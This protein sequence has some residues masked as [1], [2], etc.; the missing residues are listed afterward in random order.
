M[1]TNTRYLVL[2]CTV[3]MSLILYVDRVCL[4]G[5]RSEFSKELQ[6]SPEQADLVFSAFF[7]SYALSQVFAGAL[8]RAIGQRLM[9]TLSLLVWSLFTLASG[10]AV[11]LFMLVACRIMV[12]ISQ[13]GAYPS[14]AALVKNWFPLVR[15]GFA[16][17]MVALGGRFGGALGTYITPLLLLALVGISGFSSWRVT[18]I[19]FGAVG[20]IYAV[21]YWFLVRD[22]ATQHPWANPAEAALAEPEVHTK[23]QERTPWL[24]LLTTPNLWYSGFTQF[25]INVGWAFLV[26]KLPEYLETVHGLVG[27]AKG[28]WSS[29]P[30]LIGIIGMFF[31]GFI[32]DAL[33]KRLGV[34]WGR[35]LPLGSALLICST[36]YILAAG[37]AD[38]RLIVVLLCIMAVFVDIGVPAI[39]A[40]SQD[41]GGKHVAAALGFGNML[42]NFGAAISP[43]LLGVIQ[44]SQGWPVVFL[45]CGA[46][47]A[48]AAGL[49]LCM[50]ANKP[51]LPVTPQ[52]GD[53][54]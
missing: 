44:R 24:A 15:R 26:T 33:T 25:G 30:L 19:L 12:G 5:M 7:F 43:L 48:I 36:A 17:S 42:G 29:Y 46:S 51:L 23:Q 39:W 14:A 4:A 11:G 28:Q 34:R 22:T 37:S 47:F 40:F 35:A 21:L 18:L 1:P 38:Y 9:L 41:I 8:A 53:P 13:A 32:T 45:F 52:H 2:A 31:G 54:A 10:L 49:A 20:M 16:N 6:L 50:N 27:E 3:V